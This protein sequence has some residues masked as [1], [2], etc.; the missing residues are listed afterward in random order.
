MAKGTKGVKST[1]TKGT[2]SKSALMSGQG[3]E[4]QVMDILDKGV[5]VESLEFVQSELKRI[6]E[7]AWDKL[8]NERL[9]QAP[10]VATTEKD[11]DGNLLK[12]DKGKVL[13]IPSP[14]YVEGIVRA[15]VNTETQG[16]T[17]SHCLGFFQP[18]RFQ[19]SETGDKLGLINFCPEF[20]NPDNPQYEED[21]VHEFAQVAIHETVHMMNSANGL[22]DCSKQRHNELFK[23][24]GTYIGLDFSPS[25]DGKDK[26]IGWGR[27]KLSDEL[28]AEVDKLNINA[29][30]LRFFATEM[31]PK[32]SNRSKQVKWAC[33]SEGCGVSFRTSSS[34]N[35]NIACMD[36]TDIDDTEGLGTID[37]VVLFERVKVD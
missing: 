22:Q 33:P 13:K 28:R 27:T 17:A 20:L 18:N 12:D 14:T 19:D 6:V 15:M 16:R 7:F 32:K 30:A 31:A 37:N 24:M 29:D 11:A 8:K 34:K 35:F 23:R 2:G 36:C 21:I 9:H 10:M 25:G 5:K 1:T 26:K 4:D 3:I